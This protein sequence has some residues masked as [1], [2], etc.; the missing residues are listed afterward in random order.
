[1]DRQKT[2]D[3]LAGPPMPRVPAVPSIARFSKL[4][5]LSLTT[6]YPNVK[7]HNKCASSCLSSNLRGGSAA[8]RPPVRRHRKGGTIAGSVATKWVSVLLFPCDSQWGL[9][10]C[11]WSN[12]PSDTWYWKVTMEALLLIGRQFCKTLCQAVLQVMDLAALC[13]SIPR[14]GLGNFS[15]QLQHCG[16]TSSATQ[17]CTPVL[18]L[19]KHVCESAYLLC[20]NKGQDDSLGRFS[21]SATPVLCLYCSAGAF[22][23]NL[24][25]AA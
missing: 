10:A 22:C 17:G 9:H 15:M 8:D 20:T 3:S 14:S 5:G 4:P 6:V 7:P 24:D 19:V 23:N 18:M 21:A 1:M 25:A 12:T 2:F 11:A 13:F 16:T